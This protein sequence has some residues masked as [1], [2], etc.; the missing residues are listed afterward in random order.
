MAVQ[1]GLESVK[2]EKNRESFASWLMGEMSYV[3]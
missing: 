2:N 1:A 3:S